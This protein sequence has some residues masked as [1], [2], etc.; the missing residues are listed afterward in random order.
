MDLG[1]ILAVV[2]VVGV[3]FYIVNRKKGDGGAG[4][5]TIPSDPPNDPTNPGDGN[6]Q[7]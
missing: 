5:G 2:V 3:A 6:S 1:V 7:Q 4:D